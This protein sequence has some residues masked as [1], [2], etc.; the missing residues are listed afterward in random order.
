MTK[1]QKRLEEIRKA[2]EAENVSY[3]EIAE[4]QSL[5]EFIAKDDVLLLEWA[6][7]PEH[8][9]KYA[10]GFWYTEHGT[11]Y[12]EAE[13][14]EDAEDKVMDILQNDGLDSLYYKCN[15]RDY[16]AQDAELV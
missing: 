6:G 15:D 14:V 12:V 2:I 13:S 16:G 3:G 1:E 9:K 10:V 11:A 5:K 8:G 7:V 4:L